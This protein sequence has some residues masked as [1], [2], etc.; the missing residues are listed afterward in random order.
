MAKQRLKRTVSTVQDIVKSY[1]EDTATTI[2]S[3]NLGSLSLSGTVDMNNNDIQDIS[4]LNI[5]D[6]GGQLDGGFSGYRNDQQTD[7]DIVNLTPLGTQSS[8]LFRDAENIT[9]KVIINNGGDIDILNSDLDLNDN[10]ITNADRV[11]VSEIAFDNIEEP[12]TDRAIG[13]NDSEGI[14]FKDATN[15]VYPLWNSQSVTA[16]DN[17]SISGGVGAGATPITVSVSGGS[18][19][20]LDADTVDGKEAADLGLDI[21]DNGSLGLAGATGINF[22]NRLS[23]TDDGDGT[24]TVDGSHNHDSRYYRSENGNEL[25]IQGSSP[26]NASDGDIWINNS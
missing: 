15:T 20:G 1:L 11:G 12:S 2:Q 21:Q 23:V 17:I 18:G 3:L 7:I 24:V 14:L 5:D 4:N 13:L 26:N 10:P 16:G 19:S 8:I 6:S 9:D 25:Y 22:T